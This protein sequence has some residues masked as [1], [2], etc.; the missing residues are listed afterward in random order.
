MCVLMCTYYQ[1]N[2]LK[3][4]GADDLMHFKQ[5]YSFWSENYL[6]MSNI[7]VGSKK[8]CIFMGYLNDIITNPVVR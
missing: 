8:M 2:Y 5:D 6:S 4:Y 1:L 7:P 3:P